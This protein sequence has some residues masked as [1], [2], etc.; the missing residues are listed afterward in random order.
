MRAFLSR[1]PHQR[2]IQAR[3]GEGRWPPRGRG[4]P[5][6]TGFRTEQ[7]RPEI[8]Q[9]QSALHEEQNE[10]AQ[11]G[12]ITLAPTAVSALK[13]HVRARTMTQGSCSITVLG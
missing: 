3:H 5:S 13:S 11:T 8:T 6:A 4:W 10:S 9:S 12:T 1:W 7:S 2:I